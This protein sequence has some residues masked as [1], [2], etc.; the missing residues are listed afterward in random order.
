MISNSNPATEPEV[1][2][3]LVKSITHEAPGIHSLELVDPQGAELP[4]FDA[5]AHIDLHLGGIGARSYSLLNSPQER[6]RYVVAVQKQ[7]AGR[8]GSR[9]V[10]DVIRVG[11]AVTVGGPRNNFP[12]AAD[13]PAS[14]FI[15]GGI[16]VTPFLAMASHLRALGR[17]WKL[18]YI[19]KSADSTAF[20]QR[21]RDLA[22]DD[23]QVE[24]HF[25]RAPQGRRPALPDLI[26]SLDRGAHVYCCGPEAMIQAFEQATQ[27]LPA[28]QVH[29]ER[30]AATQA[31]DASGGFTVNAVRSAKMV[32]VEPGKT[33]LDALLDAGIDVAYSCM[34]GVCAACETRVIEGT[35]EHRDAVLSPAE[36]QSNA[37]MM[38]CCS[39]SKSSLLVLDV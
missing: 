34:E 27:G 8:G 3:L 11:D 32:F 18:H 14:V 29:L 6:H 35:P 33:I 31:A 10:H 21:L 24:I 17:P 37:T 1:L 38:V 15:A 36:R 16:G 22:D 30:F 23:S 13:A 7:A 2:K 20:T 9:H 28:G 26:A 12:L 5:G 39:G 25:T 4:A 19:V